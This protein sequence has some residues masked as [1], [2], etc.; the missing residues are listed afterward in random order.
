MAEVV[1][2]RMARKRRDRADKAKAA[3]RARMVHGQSK[4]DKALS[5]AEAERI[6]RTIEGAR[7]EG[8]A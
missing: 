2:L 7:R 5:K 1:N 8:D 3:A 6:A 4:A